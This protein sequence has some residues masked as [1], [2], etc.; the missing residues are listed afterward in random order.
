[1]LPKFARPHALKLFNLWPPF[2]AAGIHIDRIAPDFREIDVSLRLRPW[3]RNYVGTHYGGSLFSMTD[4]FYMIMLLENLGPDFIVWDKAATIHYR[5]PGR[6][7]VRAKFRLTDERL[8]ELRGEL[9]TRE[10]IEPV[11][12]ARVMD[13]KGEIVADVEK[14]LYVR[15]KG[16]VKA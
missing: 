15:R 10:K 5:K 1:M 2:A 6:G 9:E 3:N 14:T 16:P 4:P 13:D 8:L 12:V 7:T 11:F